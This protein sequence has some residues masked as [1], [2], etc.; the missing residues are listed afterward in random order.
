[1]RLTRRGRNAV[2]RSTR[3]RSTAWIRTW[4]AFWT[5]C[6]PADKEDNTLIL[7]LADNGGC[8]EYPAPGNRTYSVPDQTRNGR[9]VETGNVPGTHAGRRRHISKLRHRLGQR[10][11][12]SLPPLQALGAR[13][14]H[15]DTADCALAQGIARRN[16]ITHEPA[17]LIDL[18][19]HLRRPLGRAVSGAALRAL[20]IVPMEGGVCA[21]RSAGKPIRR[22]DAIY[23]EHEGASAPCSTASGSWCRASRTVRSC[24]ISKPTAARLNDLAAQDSDRGRAWR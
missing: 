17:H 2:W 21:P 4:V 3:R 8:A 16:A 20:A 23:W 22:D 15:L 18:M 12:H 19:G 1:M 7:F 6:A 5:P 14:R 24:T 10:V 9:P 13:G 11:E